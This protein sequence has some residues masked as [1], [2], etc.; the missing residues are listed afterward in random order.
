MKAGI[1]PTDVR[2][3][4]GIR[5]SLVQL[6]AALEI[7][8][9]HKA[10]PSSTSDLS[11]IWRIIQAYQASEVNAE[12]GQCSTCDFFGPGTTHLGDAPADVHVTETEFYAAL[13]NIPGWVYDAR[14]DSS[15]STVQRRTHILELLSIKLSEKMVFPIP[16]EYLTSWL[17]FT[18]WCA[19]FDFGSKP[20][21][22]GSW[23]SQAFR[24]LTDAGALPD[25]VPV[26]QVITEIMTY[27]QLYTA[28]DPRIIW[29]T[30][31]ARQERMIPRISKLMEYIFGFPHLLPWFTGRLDPSTPAYV[32][33][34]DDASA[35][36]AIE[37]V[38]D[39]S[40]ALGQ[41]AEFCL[42]AVRIR[43][44]DTGSASPS[45][46][47]DPSVLAR[48]IREITKQNAVAAADQLEAT[49]EKQLANDITDG[50]R[51]SAAQGAQT[52]QMP[53]VQALLASLLSKVN[54]AS[55]PSKVM[56]DVLL[57]LQMNTHC[58]ILVASPP[59]STW[60]RTG[61]IYSDKNL[62]AAASIEL[63]NQVTLAPRP[64]RG[65]PPPLAGLPVALA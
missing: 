44:D 43:R 20:Q 21:P 27:I 37:D 41:A 17:K 3:T 54:S 52:L 55:D 60:S 38:Q 64:S 45:Q 47:S 36:N 53:E 33:T 8:D 63:Q 1:N 51:F 26:I 48:S 5:L 59:P 16:G 65:R 39:D 9:V 61:E 10:S 11:M 6:A 18:Q 31:F 2:N 62:I 34:T 25:D 56:P 29:E 50:N 57:A 4:N 35:M 58:S 40:K 49:S 22:D 23:G 7:S 12:R 19:A 15:R 14:D 13:M 46:P 32:L 24:R 28:K 30:I 42:F